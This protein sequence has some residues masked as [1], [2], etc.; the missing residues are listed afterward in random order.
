MEEGMHSGGGHFEA[1]D[2]NLTVFALANGVDLYR[3]DG[4]R[5]LEWFTEGLERGI[6]IEARESGRFR[7]RALTWRSGEPE[8]RSE[9]SVAEELGVDE[10]KGVLAE[11]IEVANGLSAPEPR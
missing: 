9:A 7:V 11:A 10:M 1:I 3:G 4:H 6:L 5:R 2:S 8:A